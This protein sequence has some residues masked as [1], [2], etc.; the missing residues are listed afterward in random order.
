[1]KIYFVVKNLL[2]QEPKTRDSDRLLIWKVWEKCGYTR[3][4]DDPSDDLIYRS[5]F[6]KA[7]HTE[8]IRRLRQKLQ[9]YY[10]ELRSSKKVQESKNTK[11]KMAGNFIYQEK[12]NI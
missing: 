12:I 1:M 6:L 9:A 11:E 5:D 3:F 7:P 4:E 8:S 10:P 2:K